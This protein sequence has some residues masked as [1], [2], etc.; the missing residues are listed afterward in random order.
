MFLWPVP[1]YP[2]VTSGYDDWRPYGL[3]G[4]IDIGAPKVP[5]VAIGVGSVMWIG[6]AGD[7][8]LCVYLKMGGFRAHYCH[9]DSVNV[10]VGQAVQIGEVIG[11]VGASTRGTLDYPGYPNHLHLNLFTSVRPV[12]GPSH[13]VGWV[14]MWCVDPERYLGVAQEE[15]SNLPDPIFKTPS[16]KRAQVGVA[17]KHPIGDDEHERALIAGGA[18]VVTISE[19]LWNLLAVVKR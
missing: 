4:A 16:G 18:K 6:W 2:N 17:G 7:A 14:G 8:G 12:A 3:H 10:S 5:T 11:I 13:W 15:D 19:R 1:G 9:L